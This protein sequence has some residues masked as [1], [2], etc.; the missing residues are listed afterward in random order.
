MHLSF[1]YHFLSGLIWE[2]YLPPPQKVCAWERG[3]EE[4]P[5]SGNLRHSCSDI[6]NTA[7][8]PPGDAETQKKNNGLTGFY[9]K[10]GTN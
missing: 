1:S 2:L 4:K 8:F 10:N 6:A 3:L 7:R 9:G 5:V